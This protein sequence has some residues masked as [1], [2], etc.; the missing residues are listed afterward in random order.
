MWYLWGVSTPASNSAL[1]Q[2]LV[3]P[4]VGRGPEGLP[5][6]WG[7]IRP[8]SQWDPDLESDP[9]S[10]TPSDCGFAPLFSC[11]DSGCS[12]LLAC[13]AGLQ[14]RAFPEAI[15]FSPTSLNTRVSLN[16]GKGDFCLHYTFLFILSHCLILLLPLP[17]PSV[18]LW[19]EE[20][21]ASFFPCWISFGKHHQVMNHFLQTASAALAQWWSCLYSPNLLQ[22]KATLFQFAQWVFMSTWNTAAQLCTCTIFRAT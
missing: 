15:A 8:S 14:E 18:L 10:P 9:C 17:V 5:W 13:S 16:H 19:H 2:L 4:H 11:R 21:S 7:P 3:N 20:P 22:W 6:F 1:S 12:T